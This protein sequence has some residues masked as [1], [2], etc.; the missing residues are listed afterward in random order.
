MGRRLFTGAQRFD[1]GAPACVACHHHAGVG[2]IGGGTLGPDLTETFEKLGD[3]MVTVW[4]E[5]VAP[6]APIYS[7]RPLT[8]QE[9][10]DLLAFFSSDPEP[11]SAIWRNWLV[12][13]LA[14]GG[15]VSLFVVEGTVWRNRHHGVR[16]W[17]V[18]AARER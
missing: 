14:L 5:S 12:A 2:G 18:E 15:A 8:S 9:A 17:M 13:V 7:R 3:P 16:R 10:T 11:V 6:M 4:P 1:L